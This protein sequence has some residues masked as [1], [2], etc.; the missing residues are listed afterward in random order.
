LFSLKSLFKIDYL[1]RQNIIKFFFYLFKKYSYGRL[2]VNSDVHISLGGT[3][4][5]VC[6]SCSI[7]ATSS[8]PNPYFSF[9]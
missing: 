7:C 4:F 9:T 8:T 3:F 1:Y 2:L 6:A 5:Q